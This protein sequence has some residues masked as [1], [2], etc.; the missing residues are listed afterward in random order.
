M[1]E[2]ASLLLL[3][4]VLCGIGSMG[5]LA[6]AMPVH[7]V[8]VWGHVPGRTVLRRLRWLGAGGVVLALILCLLADHASMAILVW[9]MALSASALLIAYLLA[10][11]PRCLRLL[12][13]WL[14]ASV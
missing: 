11:R 14:R 13:P 6:L 3:S 1:H 9:T 10:S 12:A 8:Q 7:A 4:A 5:W 2:H